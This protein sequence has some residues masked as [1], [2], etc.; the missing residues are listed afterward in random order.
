MIQSFER[1]IEHI[2]RQFSLCIL[3]MDILRRERTVIAGLD[4]AAFDLL[5]REKETILSRIFDCDSDRVRLA[6]SCGLG[7]KTLSEIAAVAEGGAGARLA[8]ISSRF[9]SLL[10]EMSEQIDINKAL[11][12]SSLYHMKKSSQF[13]G[14]LDVRAPQKVSREA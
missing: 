10:S 14:S 12:D 5:V 7:N 6:E 9:R 8:D 11:I 1:L 13:L 2:E 3:L 4:T